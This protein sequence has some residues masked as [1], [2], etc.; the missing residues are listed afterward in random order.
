MEERVDQKKNLHICIYITEHTKRNICMVW[1]KE[2]EIEI[3]RVKGRK[4]YKVVVEKTNTIAFQLIFMKLRKLLCCH[5]PHVFVEG[6]IQ[7]QRLC[8]VRLLYSI[9]LYSA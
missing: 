4:R 5:A 3:H 7:T 1:H 9:Q 8:D 2:G 6:T